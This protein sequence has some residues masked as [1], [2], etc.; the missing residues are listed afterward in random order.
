MGK[1]VFEKIFTLLQ[2]HPCYL[3]N[4]ITNTSMNKHTKEAVNLLKAV[5]GYK[6][7]KND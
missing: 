7:I 1:K 4:W 3:I 6:E 5:F 2:I